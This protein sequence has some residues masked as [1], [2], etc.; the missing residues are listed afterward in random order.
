MDRG[1]IFILV[2]LFCLQDIQDVLASATGMPITE[3]IYQST[4]SRAAAA[5][6]TLGLA[7][8]FI[9]GTN[10]AVTAVS[11]LIYSLARDGGVPCSV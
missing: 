11:R 10:G 6:L 5:I 2:L 8:C 1:L 9:N 4:G 3:L 7:I